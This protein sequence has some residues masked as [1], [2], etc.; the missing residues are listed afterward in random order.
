VSPACR[1][2]QGDITIHELLHHGP[3]AVSSG[4][5]IAIFFSITT[6]KPKASRV[7][8]FTHNGSSRYQIIISYHIN[9]I[10]PAAAN[11]STIMQAKSLQRLACMSIPPQGSS[12]GAR[13]WSDTLDIGELQPRK[14][15]LAPWRY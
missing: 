7:P 9:Q 2:P 13:G 4:S 6:A 10:S 11:V 1:A 14:G 15:F 12:L 3:L 5:D 8:H